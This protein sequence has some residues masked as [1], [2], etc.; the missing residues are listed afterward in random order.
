MNHIAMIKLQTVSYQYH[1]VSSFITITEY[2]QGHYSY[3]SSIIYLQ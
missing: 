2:D 3:I 1:P